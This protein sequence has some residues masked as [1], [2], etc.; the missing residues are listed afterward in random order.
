MTGS[1]ESLAG[2]LLQM[3]SCAW[4]LDQ[5]QIVDP[6]DLRELADAADALAP[7]LP[8]EARAQ[9]SGRVQRMIDALGAGS[10]RLQ[11]RLTAV[12]AGR[13]AVKGY[14]ALGPGARP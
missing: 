9:L 12:R 3:D 11:A 4:K 10:A 2:L 8:P 5:D 6:E 13:R 1:V 14:A 7:T